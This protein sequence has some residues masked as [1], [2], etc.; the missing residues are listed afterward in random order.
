MYSFF[1]QLTWKKYNNFKFLSDD[2]AD[3]ED[4]IQAIDN[5]AE[6]VTSNSEEENCEIASDIDDILDLSNLTNMFVGKDGTEWTSNP[7][8]IGKT[9]SYN[10]IKEQ[11]NKVILPSGNHIA[12]A[13]DAFAL[14][15]DDEVINIMVACTN[16]YAMEKLGEIWKP[17][18]YTKIRAYFGLFIEACI[19]NGMAKWHYWL[20]WVLGPCIW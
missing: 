20:Y 3:Q 10:I 2:D 19:R 15:F 1:N 6:I 9:I 13:A 18:K 8:T 16:A 7:Y 5:L 11:I 12:T 4:V 14:L 17:T